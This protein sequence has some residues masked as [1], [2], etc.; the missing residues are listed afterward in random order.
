MIQDENSPKTGSPPHQV[1]IVPSMPTP[2]MT[3]DFHQDRK[4]LS[5][6]ERYVDTM[7]RLIALGD[8]DDDDM[9]VDDTPINSPGDNTPPPP[10]LSTNLPPLSHS[11]PRTPPPP[12]NHSLQSDAAKKGRIIKGPILNTGEQ[13]ETSDYEGCLDLGLMPQAVVSLNGNNSDIESDNDLLNPRKRKVSFSGGDHDTEFGSSSAAV[14]GDPLAPPPK[15]KSKPIFD[16]NE[17]VE[18]WRLPILEVREIMLEY[19]VVVRQKKEA[20][21]EEHLSTKLTQALTS[22]DESINVQRI[23]NQVEK[24]FN[25]NVEK[26]HIVLDLND[27]IDRKEFGDIMTQRTKLD[28]IMKVIRTKPT[29]EYLKL[30]LVRKKREYEYTEVIFARELVKFGYSECMHIHEIINKHKGIHVQEVK[31]AI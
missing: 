25:I 1:E 10:P 9:V 29:N 6:V 23:D 5:K 12:F 7:K 21:K 16:L 30:Q 24:I 13:S 20:R 14:G 3:A 17:L 8:D 22:P 18:T 31:L 28:P 2:I 19:N 15:K 11:P 26:Q 4:S 27:R